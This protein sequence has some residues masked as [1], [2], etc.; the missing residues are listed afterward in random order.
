[1]RFYGLIRG[2]RKYSRRGNGLRKGSGGGGG[3]TATSAGALNHRAI[4]WQ[5]PTGLSSSD[6]LSVVNVDR[7]YADWQ[8]N[9]LPLDMSNP[10]ERARVDRLK[11]TIQNAAATGGTFTAPELGFF[12]KNNPFGA[13]PGYDITDGRHR[14]TAFKE[15]GF[16]T[17]KAYVDN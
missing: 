11:E 13:A 2:G 3:G 16:T 17:I 6:R 9:G 1:M 5:K 10:N 12:E 8:R 4:S 15:L 14:I 7:V